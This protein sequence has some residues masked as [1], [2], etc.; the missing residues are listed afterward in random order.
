MFIEALE[1]RT[2]LSVVTLTA[3]TTK[4]LTLQSGETLNGNGHTVGGVS[5]YDVSNVTVENL[6]VNGSKG[7]GID[8]ESDKAGVSG[9]TMNNVTI[10]GFKSGYGLFIYTVGNGTFSKISLT[11]INA[12]GN[13]Q[14]GISTWGPTESITQFSLKGSSAYNNA[15]ISNGQGPSGSGIML[16][17]VNGGT[18]LQCIAYG[19]GANNDSSSGPVGIWA[20]NCNAVTI[21]QCYSYNNKT[22][23]ND[24]G[25]FDLD[26]GVTNSTIIE[27]QSWGN[28]GYG[29]ADF[30]YAGG[31]A[32]SGN[33]FIDNTST[34]DAEG[35]L[36]WSGG[37][38]ISNLTV[39]Q[40]LFIAPT[41]GYA[42]VEYSGLSY[43]NIN[44]TSNTYSAPVLVLT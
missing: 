3:N 32:N 28:V 23:M 10:W 9:L 30:A 14:A 7:D 8:I 43:V 35:F 13:G 29:F 38:T 39:S 17:G 1:S 21:T 2:F 33:S 5:G 40:N 36:Y 31:A 41:S 34:A 12:Y 27:C 6:K 18:V 15:G 16:A 20:Y 4:I 24:G 19:N 44:F 42:I 37:P 25:G 26:G 11:D 22:E